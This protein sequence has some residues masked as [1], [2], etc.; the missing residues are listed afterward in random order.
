MNA[1]KRQPKPLPPW[2]SKLLLGFFFFGMLP[3]AGYGIYVQWQ[4]KF[5]VK[6]H[7]Q[8]Q[9]FDP[10]L[11][12]LKNNDWSKMRSFRTAKTAAQLSAA[13]LEEGATKHLLKHGAPQSMRVD[14]VIQG[15]VIGK[16]AHWDV[17]V[18]YTGSKGAVD[19]SFRLRNAKNSKKS[20]RIENSYLL[21]HGVG[22]SDRIRI[23]A[24]F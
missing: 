2:L 22:Y 11:Q 12:A 14:H 19:L 24:L 7:L 10:Y 17:F 13:A 3:L 9:L 4:V 1:T 23:P 8:Q 18:R 6:P 20:F 21:A 15:G 16:G 5:D